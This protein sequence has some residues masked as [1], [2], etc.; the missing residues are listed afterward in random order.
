MTGTED[1][2]QDRDR[3]RGRKER[4]DRS[5]E[6]EGE[7]SRGREREKERTRA[8][9]RNRSEDRERKKQKRKT[10]AHEAREQGNDTRVVLQSHYFPSRQGEKRKHTQ[11]KNKEG[12]RGEQGSQKESYKL[13]KGAETKG[14]LKMERLVLAINVCMFYK[15]FKGALDLET[16][17]VH[18]PHFSQNQLYHLWFSNASKRN[19]GKERVTTLLNSWLLKDFQVD[20]RDG[21]SIDALTMT[22]EKAVEEESQFCI[23]VLWKEKPSYELL[24]KYYNLVASGSNKTLESSIEEVSFFP[25]LLVG[26]LN[27]T[28]PYQRKIDTIWVVRFREKVDLFRKVGTEYENKGLFK[29]PPVAKA[30]Y[31][32][33]LKYIVCQFN[34]SAKLTFTQECRQKEKRAGH[35]YC[36]MT[37]VAE[38]NGHPLYWPKENNQR[39]CKGDREA[40]QKP[41]NRSLFP[42][43]AKN[44]TTTPKEYNAEA[45]AA[46]G[47]NPDQDDDIRN[48]LQPVTH[49]SPLTDEAD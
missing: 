19:D 6:R 2:G 18:T 21:I 23:F 7:R 38:R 25:S 48:D 42:V 17:A 10:S 11:D 43:R 15:D 16:M 30:W 26:D 29:G 5:R 39:N 34:S 12:G 47:F 24:S 14:I 28:T 27:I 8:G 33:N 36:K 35:C 3:G 4:R 44:N 40:F 20:R 22:L 49:L 31:P 37:I 46:S 13:K 45:D 41:T 9:D 1:N 32:F